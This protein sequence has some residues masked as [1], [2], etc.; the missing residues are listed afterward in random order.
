MDLAEG[1]LLSAHIPHPRQVIK[2]VTDTIDGLVLKRSFVLDLL[3]IRI[4]TSYAHFTEHS[5]AKLS[6]REHTR[7]KARKSPEFS[8]LPRPQTAEFHVYEAEQRWLD[9]TRVSIKLGVPAAEYTY[10]QDPP[11]GDLLPYPPSWSF[12]GTFG[13]A[14]APAVLFVP[15]HPAVKSGEWEAGVRQA[16][17][18]R[19]LALNI[20]GR[21]VLTRMQDMQLHPLRTSAPR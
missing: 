8:S 5:Y 15:C 12:L 19:V 21:P 3:P 2:R 14:P 4:C 17:Y 20:D 7:S 6:Q 9:T 16:P 11:Q 13:S 18:V 1:R 10:L